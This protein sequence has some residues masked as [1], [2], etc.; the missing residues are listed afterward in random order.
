MLNRDRA[1]G[2]MKEYGID[3]LLGTTPVNHSYISDFSPWLHWMYRQITR[4]KFQFQ[5]YALFPYDQGIPAALVAPSR[6]SSMAYQA[7]WP[8]W[9][10]DLYLHGSPWDLGPEPGPE[11]PAEVH[12]I[13]QIAKIGPEKRAKTAGEALV[14]A[15]KDRGFTKGVIAIDGEG[16]D[17]AQLDKVKSELPGL[18]FKEAGE[19]FRYIRMVKTPEEITL[20]KKAAA[21]NWEGFKA[22]LNTAR[23]GATEVDLANAFRAGVSAAGAYPVFCNNASGPSA[24]NHW[25]PRPYALK[26][27]DVIYCDAGCT[28]KRYNSDENVSA[29]LGEPTKR[30]RDLFEA[31]SGGLD[32]TK[33]AIKPGVKLSEVL[34]VFKKAT[35]ASGAIKAFSGFGHAV[36]L[37]ARDMPMIQTPFE[38]AKDDIIDMSTDF[39]LEPGMI[40]NMEDA[41]REL[42]LGSVAVEDT[43]LVTAT[44]CESLTPQKREIVVLPA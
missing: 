3:A 13:Y 18:Q 19:F 28:Y 2:A 32:A 30:H 43:Y 5:H 21:V 40:F 39:T 36:G 25:E 10:E 24:I 29:V 33:A 41:K 17:P 12:R 44:G 37:E 6:P 15:F 9:I 4:D 11:Y 31:M 26:P 27:G 23:P 22:L 7:E 1:L 34:E 38:I 16:I 20:M 14:R 35:L 42:G 8:S